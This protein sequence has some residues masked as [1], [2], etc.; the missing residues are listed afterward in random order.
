[1]GKRIVGGDDQEGG[2]EQDG[3]LILK[4]RLSVY[5]LVELPLNNISHEWYI[6][7]V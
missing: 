1:M 2:S 4:N 3:K 6:A 7:E 5:S